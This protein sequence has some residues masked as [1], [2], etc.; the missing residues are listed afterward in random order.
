MKAG[1]YILQIGFFSDSVCP[2]FKTYLKILK[3]YQKHTN[4]EK[5]PTKNL[6]LKVKKPTL[7][8]NFVCFWSDT[9]FQGTN[10][11]NGSVISFSV[12]EDTTFNLFLYTLN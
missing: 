4:L 1:V 10:L 8:R 2:N 3:T 7:T 5:I 6:P 9:K 12:K 11:R